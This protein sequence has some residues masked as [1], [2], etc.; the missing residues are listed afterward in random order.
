MVESPHTFPSDDNMSS[1]SGTLV[2]GCRTRRHIRRRNSYL[3]LLAI[4]R[5][6]A[7]KGRSASFRIASNNG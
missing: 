7:G 6:A 1:P 3:G 4:G 5:R 2:R